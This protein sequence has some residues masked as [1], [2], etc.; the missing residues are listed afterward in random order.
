MLGIPLLK[1][2]EA[3]DEHLAGNVFVVGCQVTLGGLSGVVDKDVGIGSHTCNGAD[4][5]AVEQSQASS[6]F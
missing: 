6:A 1:V 2:A 4:H 5:V 3:L